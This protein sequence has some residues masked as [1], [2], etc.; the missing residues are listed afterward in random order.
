MLKLMSSSGMLNIYAIS[1]SVGTLV[2]RVL[3][4][5]VSLNSRVIE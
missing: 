3:D 4:I 2:Y 5:T 1:I